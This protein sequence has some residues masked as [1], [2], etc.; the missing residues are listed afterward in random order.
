M[1]DR[2]DLLG[3]VHSNITNLK[4]IILPVNTTFEAKGMVVMREWVNVEK[5]HEWSSYNEY[6]SDNKYVKHCKQI[7]GASYRTKACQTPSP[8]NYPII[9]GSSMISIDSTK[10]WKKLVEKFVKSNCFD[11]HPFE[12]S[13]FI[14]KTLG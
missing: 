8:T 14:E 7:I 13:Y 5:E 9:K 2:G 11:Y 3:P 10:L 4:S 6:T 12:I 1:D